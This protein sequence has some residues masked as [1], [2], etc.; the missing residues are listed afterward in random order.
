MFYRDDQLCFLCLDKSTGFCEKGLLV[1]AQI[2][3][4]KFIMSE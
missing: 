2:L 1:M 4:A 3:V